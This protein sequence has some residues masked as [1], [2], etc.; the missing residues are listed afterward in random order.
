[1]VSTYAL[2]PEISK[3]LRP[4]D[5][6][7][8]NV[9]GLVEAVDTV[10]VA[11]LVTQKY[12]IL[13]F[14][15]NRA[16]YLYIDGVYV[17]FAREFLE[18]ELFRWFEP[19]RKKNQR[20]V[21]NTQTAREILNIAFTL[22]R[23]TMDVLDRQP[24]MLNVPNGLI[25]LTTGELVAH[26]PKIISLSQI[27]AVYRPTAECPLF[28]EY[29][30]GVIAPK[31]HPA[32][33]EMFGYVLWPGYPLHKA[34]MLYGPPRTGK[35][36]M[37]GVIRA[38]LGS[39]AV[40]TVDLQRLTGSNHVVWELFGKKANIHGDLPRSIIMEPSEFKVLTG[41]DT[42][43]GE[44]K[45]K[46]GFSFNNHAKIVFGSNYIPALRFDDAAF[47]KRWVI[48]QFTRSFEENPDS[49]LKE[50]LTTPEELSGILNWSLEGLDRLRRDDFRLSYHD[51]GE[52]LY[53]RLSRPIVVFLEECT[54][55]DEDGRVPKDELFQA[56]KQWTR[57]NGSKPGT[58]NAFGRKMKD[59]DFE[60][61]RIGEAGDIRVWF[62]LRLK[63]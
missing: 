9:N 47:Y 35:S 5:C 38:M 15:E 49:R 33:Q 37:L 43:R 51:N 56:F 17:P 6:L 4:G 42:V 52:D 23:T 29:L 39:R 54:E 19:F 1:M 36:T 30:D 40:S 21:M 8:E 10:L 63:V 18:G 57:A 14:A 26:D 16:T 62:G 3:S 44:Q 59:M 25:D 31:Y 48:F 41:G 34:F 61:G 11:H 50:K 28:R 46:D 32:L 27:E 45:F 13:E 53:R 22:N 7:I 2:R 60:D 12:H 20:P 24:L 55:E 58:K